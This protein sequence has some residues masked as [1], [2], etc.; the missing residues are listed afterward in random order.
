M[1][2]KNEHH[3]ISSCTISIHDFNSEIKLFM[4]DRYYFVCSYIPD[5]S[6]LV[7]FSLDY[8][9]QNKTVKSLWLAFRSPNVE[10]LI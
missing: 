5:H 1:V 8:I 2:E 6:I 4:F 9:Q 7:L 10:K 3:L